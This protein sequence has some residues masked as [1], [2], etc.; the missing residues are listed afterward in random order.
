MN[1]LK[2]FFT[3]NRF[4]SAVG[5]WLRDFRTL[6]AMQLKEHLSFSFKAD[7]KGALTKI[8][9]FAVLLIGVTA[10]ISV[11]FWLLGY[12][13]IIGNGIIPVPLFNV[14][15]Y[16]VVILNIFS[17]L[18]KLTKSLYFSEDNQ[19]LLSY[20]VNSGV[21]FLS[22]LVV[23]Y[24]LEL[25]KSFAFLVPLFIAYG[26]TNI[27]PTNSVTV[28]IGYI[29]W[30]FFCFFII[31]FIPVA[32]G[33]VLSI[34]YMYVLTFLKRSQYIQSVLAFL[35]I[36]T[37]IVF[38]FIGFSKIPAD[39]KIA[40]NWATT[41]YPRV[42][43]FSEN[44]EKFSGPLYFVPV[45][46][47]GYYGYR[48]SGNPHAL[49]IVNKSTGVVLLGYLG[50]ITVLLVIS[51]F[52]AKPLFFKMATKPFEYQKKLINHN[53]KLNIEKANIAPK[54]FR[55]KLQYPI[56]KKDQEGIINKL[57]RLLRRVNREEKIFLRRKIDNKRILRFLNKYSRSLKFEIVDAS[58]ITD[59]GFI[60]EMRNEV[61]FLVLVK[62]KKNGVYSCY[63]PFYLGKKN[64]VKD[65]KLSLFVKEILL[66]IRTPGQAIS[67][68]LLFVIT[69]LAIS[70]LNALF[71]AINTSFQGKTYV[72]MFNVLIIMLIVLA[73]NVTMASIY[74]REGKTSYM[75]KAMPVNYMASLGFKLL[76]RATIVVASLALTMVLY[77]TYCKITFIR[78]DLL[79]FT[80]VFIYLGHLLWSA[81]LDFM[82][83]KDNLYAALGQNV[84]NPNETT[85]AILTFIISFAMM[86]ISFFLISTEVSRA[87]IKLFIIG[88][89]FFLIRLGLFVLKILAYGTSRAERRDS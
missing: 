24:I 3:I 5:H 72:I 40:S 9:I 36:V 66:D 68:I 76:I 43:D 11:V 27:I 8:I 20:P 17:C 7:K 33:A 46:V 61:P 86:G 67:M 69:P 23:F 22:K 55:P 6:V 62:N 42:L 16:F 41:Y 71:A 52:L 21:I 19:V 81:E 53:Y 34:P 15:L 54:A 10:V 63:D 26:I 25:V 49:K 74:S 29:P 14:L 4:F 58:E 85:S 45:L 56:S 60:V 89:V 73:S 18:H 80:F 88:L 82:N 65:K 30:V 31:S 77:S 44:V 1:K 64:R 47:L 59:F 12:L 13:K 37:V 78:Y 75:L 28:M 87:F 51:Y 38:L 48:F 57:S 39:L 50:V 32:I 35:G 2:N 83:P 84:N 79:F 70:L